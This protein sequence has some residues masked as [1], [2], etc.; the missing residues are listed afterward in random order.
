MRINFWRNELLHHKIFLGI[1]WYFL[2]KKAAIFKIN[3]TNLIMF[4]Y[5]NFL[6]IK[7]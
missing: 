3:S 1:I 6:N 5:L 7:I 4:I 2:R